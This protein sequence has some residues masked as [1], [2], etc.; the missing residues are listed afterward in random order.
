MDTRFCI[1]L[2][3]LAL[4]GGLYAIFHGSLLLGVALLVA[5]FLWWREAGVRF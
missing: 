5:C 4:I 2:T 3:V 1:V